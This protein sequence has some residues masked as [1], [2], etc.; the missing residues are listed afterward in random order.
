MLLYLL[1]TQI[2]WLF[3]YGLYAATLSRETFFRLNRIYLLATLLL[4]ILL[5][6][7]PMVVDFSMLKISPILSPVV[8]TAV[9]WT[10]VFRADTEGR[11]FPLKKYFF[12][13]IVLDLPLP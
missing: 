9:E 13:F 8:G 10:P 11:F 3:F 7:V 12:A 1:Q 6:F 4:G 5:P 2:A